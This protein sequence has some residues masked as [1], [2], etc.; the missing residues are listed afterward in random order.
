MLFQPVW[1]EKL[2]CTCKAGG[3]V[4][5][6]PMGVVSVYLPPERVWREQAPPWAAA[7]W[8][9]IEAQLRA[10]CV[11]QKIPLHIDDN[12]EVQPLQR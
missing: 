8:T 10:W 12:A 4:L 5:D 6:M 3:F 1:K 11:A 9:A 2:I 7:H